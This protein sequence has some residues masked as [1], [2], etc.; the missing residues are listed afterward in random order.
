MSIKL[1]SILVVANFVITLLFM[2][3]VYMAVIKPT[4]GFFGSKT[5]GDMQGWMFQEN[6]DLK[7][8][9]EEDNE[10]VIVS[11]GQ[12]SKDLKD[13]VTAE[14]QKL[15][16]WVNEANADTVKYC[17]NMWSERQGR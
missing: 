15:H 16:D 7:T 10:G 17:E 9:I 14:N 13:F 1:L 3:Y 4:Q 5:Y 2:G 8:W 11:N 6:E 12:Y